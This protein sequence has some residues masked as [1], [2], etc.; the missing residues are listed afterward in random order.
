MANHSA[1]SEAHAEHGHS[2]MRYYASFAAL[3][4]FTVL[5]YALHHVDLGTMAL[6]IA[7][8]IATGKAL[9]VVLFFMH[10]WDHPGV[11]RLVFGVTV[12]FLFFAI[13]MVF[14]DVFTR[15]P[16]AMPHYP[17]PPPASFPHT[18]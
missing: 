12:L 4:V 2:A 16:L 3:F 18:K 15:Y 7:M 9:V 10:L 13:I 14:A 1:H 6:P 11:N 8:L 17:G 5:T